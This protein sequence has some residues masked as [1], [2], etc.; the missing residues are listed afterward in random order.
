MP[1]IEEPRRSEVPIERQ[2]LLEA[3]AAHDGEAQRIDE[4]VRALIVAEQ[5]PQGLLF[6]RP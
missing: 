3:P 4:G 2:R 5:L 6:D 1:Q